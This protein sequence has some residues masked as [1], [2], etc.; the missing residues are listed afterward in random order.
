M[1]EEVRQ[2]L[3]GEVEVLSH[4]LNVTLPAALEKA[5]AMGDLKENGDYHAALERQRFVQARLSQ[6][7]QRLVKI[8]QI[9]TAKIPNDRVGLGSQVVVQ[10]MKTKEKETYELVIP[11][12]MDPDLGHI[13]VSSPLGS[14]LTGCKPGDVTEAKLPIGPRKLKVL[15]LKTL[16]DIAKEDLQ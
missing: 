5:I 7:T 11:D 2:K 12:A 6:L 4:E 13:S 8:S 15:K 1:I 14:A 16:H 10:D 3:Q 9:D